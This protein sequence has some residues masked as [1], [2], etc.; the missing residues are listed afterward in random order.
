MG[1]L[2]RKRA[3]VSISTALSGRRQLGWPLNPPMNRLAMLL[4]VDGMKSCF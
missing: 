4:H 2:S 1:Q 3:A